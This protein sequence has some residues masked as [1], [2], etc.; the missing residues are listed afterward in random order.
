[1]LCDDGVV[2]RKEAAWALANATSGGTFEQIS[3]LV[4]EGCIAAFVGAIGVN[5]DMDKGEFFGGWP[6]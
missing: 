1:M 5:N 2:V 3:N 4:D 6:S